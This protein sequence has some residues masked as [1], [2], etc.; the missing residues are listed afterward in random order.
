MTKPDFDKAM[1]AAV[2][3]FI[4]CLEEENVNPFDPEQNEEFEDAKDDFMGMIHDK[5]DM[6]YYWDDE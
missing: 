2:A 3:A 4:V 5:L 6:E 1:D